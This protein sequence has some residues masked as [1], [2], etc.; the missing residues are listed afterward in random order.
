VTIEDAIHGVERGLAMEG[1][2]TADDIF[3]VQGIK[4]K[5]NPCLT[6]KLQLESKKQMEIQ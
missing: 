4:P 1:K 6:L 2:A 5:P 3:R